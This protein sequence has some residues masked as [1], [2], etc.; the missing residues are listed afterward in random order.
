MLLCIRYEDKFQYRSRYVS[1]ISPQHICPRY[2]FCI[3]KWE[4]TRVL[5]NAV[6]CSGSANAAWRSQRLNI[7]IQGTGTRQLNS[8]N[9]EQ[10][11]RSMNTPL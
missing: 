4:L 6:V 3:Q 10:R 7:I 11:T 8:D 9:Y 2:E 1:A 5:L